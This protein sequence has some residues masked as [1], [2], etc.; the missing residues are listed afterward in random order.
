MECKGIDLVN[1]IDRMPPGYFP[2]LFNVRVLQEGRIEGR[3]GYQPLISLVD[4]PNSVRRL[5][6]PN[7][8]IYVGGGGG[9]LYQGDESTYAP[10]EAGYSGDPLSL[11]PFR[12]EQ[13][14]DAWMYVYDRNKSAKVG[15]FGDLRRVGVAPPTAA[16]IIEYG[17]PAFVD[18]STG[19][20]TAGW[21]ATGGSAGP[22]LQDRTN[23]S[24]PSIV[25]ITYVDGASGW[26]CINPNI[27]QPFWMGDRMEVIL[28]PGGG[29]EENVLV[30]NVIQ[31]IKNTT[32][33]NIQYD[34]GSDGLCSVVLTETPAGLQRNSLV[35]IDS[36]VVRVLEVNLS[37]D[38]VVYSFRC[39]T[40]LLHG[41]GSPVT[42][43]ISWFVYTLQ[44][45]S[46]GELIG[47]Q[48]VQAVQAAMGTGAIQLTSNINVS[49]ANGRPI[50]PANDYLHISLFFSDP[51][52][53]TDIKLLLSL[54][55]APNFSFTNPGNSY[56]WTLTKDQLK[57]QGASS[58]SWVDIVVPISQATRSGSDFTRTLATISGIAIQLDSSAACT[59]GFDWWYVFGTYGPVI[60]PASPVGYI[61]QSRFRDSTTGAHSVPSP[62]T[63]Y[64]LFPLREAV[65]ITPLAS[66]QAGV[67]TI[68]IYRQ[69]GS[70]SSPLYVGSVENN[71]GAP[72][73]YIDKLP[74]SAVLKVNQP[75]D[76]TAFQPWPTLATPR[77]G[78]VFV[79]GTSV[80]YLSGDPF[81]L[82]LVSNSVI[83]INGN[84]YQTY[85]QPRSRT[86]LELTQDA[87]YLNTANYQID[88]PTLA[89]QPLPFAFGALE[90][91]FAPV[92]FALGDPVNGGLLY[93]TNF[94]D[95]DS[96][97]SSNTL[98]LT[99][100]SSDLVSGAIWN[101]ICFAGDRDSIY[102]VRYTYLTG[103][104]SIAFQWSKVGAAPSGIWSRWACC[105]CPIGMAYLGRDGIYIATDSGAVN[106]T[107]D[108]LYPLFPHDGVPAKAVNSG[109]NIILPVDMNMLTKLRLSYCD[110]ALRF[111]YQDSGGNYN[112]LI[113]EIYK[114]RWFLN[115]YN[116]AIS[117]HYL[118]EESAN[119]TNDQLILMLAL[120][121]KKI[122]VA[123]DDRDGDADIN[124]IVL[125]PSLDG[126]D[127]RAQKLYVDSMTQADGSGQLRLAAAYDNAQSFSPVLTINC[128]GS[129]QQ[130]LQN[131]SSLA[132]LTLYRN[133]GA[134][135]AWVGGPNGPRIYAWEMSGFVQPYLS[136][137][138]V[139]QQIPFSF[140]GWKHMRRMFPA[141][142]SNGPVVFTV[143]SQDGRT[144][145]PYTIP[146]TSGKYRI[147]P[148][149]LDQNIK[150]LA[151][152]L[153]LDGRG[154]SFA[155]FPTDFT[156]EVKEWTE[157]S[158]IKLAVFRS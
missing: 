119:G 12:P 104:G 68:D 141:L 80:I 37:P 125:T 74:D 76:V 33:A 147:L 136:S 120:D 65:M 29:N 127:E 103:V 129:I 18:I 123:Q 73:T 53:V 116:N 134:K 128:F 36:E 31:P 137:K 89:A 49:A 45:H 16:P 146:T 157:E 114:K 62:V 13:S 92:I 138:F 154:R 144:Y 38:G 98:E 85:G 97:A 135:F 47:S 78:E 56:I 61:Y 58:S 121:I 52:A 113:Y 99:T 10:I 2:Y 112:T 55:V 155:F 153:E 124:S 23:A 83:L 142:I 117:F 158:Y 106:I 133:I 91:P 105:T 115:N 156:V 17:V 131:I 132:D 9:N 1:P 87:G 4:T 143:K 34:V 54:D 86:F 67:D 118:A 111:S 75:P 50:D 140:P 28:N 130:T 79:V 139:T 43:L 24:T 51:S 82:D 22:T 100:P 150:D 72:N 66:E 90:G 20:S 109:S 149:M 102:T 14:T 70:I 152:A 41:M 25:S 11:I 15:A 48:Y 81:D 46:I 60:D 57:I 63:R 19:Q 7:G 69:G 77:R 39:S 122:V 32:V 108:Q 145:G 3:P 59:Y 84:A 110:E 5:N 151:F 88:S 27:T 101:G 94:S 44:T 93:Y 107:D 40:G 96:A 21:S 8:H 71:F 35:A 148:Q 64:D 6:R 42:G 26:A 30:R 95:A 126:G